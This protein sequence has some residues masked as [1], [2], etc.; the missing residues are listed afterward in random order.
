MEHRTKASIQSGPKVV[1]PGVVHPNELLL[2][3]NGLS[4]VNKVV[5]DVAARVLGS[6]YFFYFCL[7]LDLIELPPVIMSNSIIL[8][9]N[10]IA[11]TVIQL[12]ALPLLQAYQNT[13]QKQA[14]A[15]ADADHRTLVHIATHQDEDSEKIDQIL[16]LLK[17]GKK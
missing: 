4:R 6:P 10:Y 16:S 2:P 12:V 13:L 3:R 14:D 15:K 1:H 11:Q 17:K 8:W 9:I 5:I 7:V